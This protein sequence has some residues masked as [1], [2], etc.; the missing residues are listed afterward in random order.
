[1]TLD[2]MARTIVE[3]V[4]KVAELEELLNQRVEDLAIR[5][6][7]QSYDIDDV[8]RDVRYLEDHV[9]DVEYE[10]GSHEH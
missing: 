6:D 5:I 3:L 10:L 8:I 9:H 7:H 4:N 2:E 1:M